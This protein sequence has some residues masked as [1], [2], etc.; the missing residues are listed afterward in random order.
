MPCYDDY[1]NVLIADSLDRV[2][3][4][5]REITGGSMDI[6]TPR[7]TVNG[8][9]CAVVT[10]EGMVSGEVVG[11][12]VLYPLMSLVSGDI[13]TPREI[14]RFCTEGSIFSANKT[15]CYTYGSAVGLL[16]SGFA[17]VFADGVPFAAAF[18]IQGYASRAVAPPATENEL[19]ASQEGF[20][21]VVR[22][23]ISLIRRR[24][25]HPALTFEMTKCGR[26]SATD[27]CIVYVRGKAD[28]RAVGRIR[29]R[30]SEIK[31]D[32]VLTPGF[33]LPFLEEDEGRRLF[34]EVGTTE[35]PDLL[36]AELIQGR[37]GV[38][39]DGTPFALVCPY[40]FAENFGTV[41]DY[42]V[43]TYYAAFVRLMRWLAFILAA[44][45]PGVYL[46]AVNHDPEMLN[47]K[48]LLNLAAGEKTTLLTL[49]TEL[50]IVML[51]LEILREASI[52][53]PHAIGTAMSIAGGLI[54][55]DTAVKSGIISSPLL[56]IVGV[57]ATA[58]F[59]LPAFSQQISVLRLAFIFAGGFAGFFGISAC[60]V[61]LTAN[62]CSQSLEGVPFGSPAAP[63]RPR[64]LISAF[65]RKSFRR[66]ERETTTV[67]DMK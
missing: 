32:S 52:R 36:C 15:V 26:L 1:E 56:I 3:A 38:L 66:M 67:K 47:L 62:I 21:E 42:S 28:M 11:E 23:N 37:I 64:E 8:V 29:R 45:F 33:L 6:N 58:S 16:F 48:L 43:K 14:M 35:R 27:V 34:S 19:L 12:L 7:V 31:L 60:A 25:K 17:L 57:T 53:L 9:D 5:L 41:D 13:D 59:V 54:I 24:I 2:L 46:A 63:L 65:G 4:D 22:T 49:F 20:A 51:L 61:M 50:V 18:G 40:L 39:I 30:L 44:T 10:V 55:G